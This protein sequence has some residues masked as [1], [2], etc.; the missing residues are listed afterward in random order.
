MRKLAHIIN[1]VVVKEVSDLFVAQPVTFATMATAR[2][3]AQAEVQVSLFTA[4]FPEDR[5]MVPAGFQTTPDLT[6]SVLDLNSFREQ[7]KLP[8]LKDI[9]YSVYEAAPDA[10]YLIYT[11][12][13]I[14]LQPHFYIEVSRYIDEGYDAFVINRRTLPKKYQS[15]E[16][17]P[18]MCADPGESH[19]GWDCFVFRREAYP[20]FILDDICVGA[21]LVGAAL[22]FNLLATSKNFIEFKDKHLT[23]HIGD[24]MSWKSH[25]F[26]DYA[27]H[28]IAAICTIISSLMAK[29]G[30]I[31]GGRYSYLFTYID[32]LKEEMKMS[33][34]TTAGCGTDALKPAQ[35]VQRPDQRVICITGMARSGTSM[36]ARILNIMGL[37]LGPQDKL[38]LKTEYNVEGCWEHKDLL[39][40]SSKLISHLG[41]SG[42]LKPDWTSD[43]AVLS[44]E[45]EARTCI[46]R[47]FQSDFWG[48]KDD[49]C[50]LTLP[51]WHNLLP[52]T[53]HIICVRNPL[54]TAKSLLKQN[55]V[56][57][58]EEGIYRWLDL[59]SSAL[60]NTQGKRRLVVFFDEFLG[61]D[62]RVP[63]RK[64]AEFMGPSYVQK[65]P[66][67]EKEIR[68]F[69]RED[70]RHHTTSLKELLDNDEIPYTVKHFYSRLRGYGTPM[71]QNGLPSC[72]EDIDGF[73]SFVHAD[74]F[75]ITQKYLEK[76]QLA[77]QKLELE[78][79]LQAE[80]DEIDVLKRALT[81]RDG[82]IEA[83]KMALAKRDAEINSFKTALADS[84][85]ENQELLD[86]LS[87]K[88]TGPLMYLYD[89]AG[90]RKGGRE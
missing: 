88:I 76:Q 53:E 10:E 26:S 83:L 9:L 72:W 18:L 11:N 32:N 4:Q 13:D 23:F 48:W 60:K 77:E 5:T 44:L 61:P 6:R 73:I 24:D 25:D 7:R 68:A 58:L 67:F 8:L 39:E 59:M 43:P 17:I 15:V 49:R 50:S 31:D 19:P 20:K 46:V 36:V 3:A 57:S 80:D 47:D 45:R 37:D 41:W 56:V 62:W 75:R 79:A 1:P 40:I 16:E 64:L 90:C 34:G 89:V 55:W 66:E 70:L 22:L 29:Y 33:A 14:A 65:L 51:F 82:E 71:G 28:N 12:V 54:D 78:R 69:I 87:W 30:D 27:A 81:E 42:F 52:D 85:L 74:A 38:I 63:V 35:P 21:N 84:N 86:S 2:D